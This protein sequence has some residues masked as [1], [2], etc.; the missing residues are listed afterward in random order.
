M[1]SP[2]NVYPHVFM[3]RESRR[4]DGRKWSDEN[5]NTFFLSLSP[6]LALSVCLLLL[7]LCFCYGTLSLCLLF[8]LPHSTPF[9]NFSFFLL[10]QLSSFIP[11]SSFCSCLSCEIL[12]THVTNVANDVS[13]GRYKYPSRASPSNS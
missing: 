8:F 11:S 1:C 12:C 13:Y 2:I 6:F 3:T 5:E 9:L 10:L 7:F 4:T